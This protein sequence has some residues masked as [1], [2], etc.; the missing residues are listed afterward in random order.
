M[1]QRNDSSLDD[2]KVLETIFNP[3]HPIMGKCSNL[4]IGNVIIVRNLGV[5]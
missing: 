2:D 1:A 5:L 3:E 4:Y